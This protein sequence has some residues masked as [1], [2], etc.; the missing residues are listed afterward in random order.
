MIWD[1]FYSL[2]K[3]ILKT[4]HESGIVLFAEDTALRYKGMMLNRSSA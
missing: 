1:P 4:Y 3:Y 2:K